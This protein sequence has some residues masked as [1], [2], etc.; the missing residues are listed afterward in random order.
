MMGSAMQEEASSL[1]KVLADPDRSKAVL[2]E[3]TRRTTEAQ[4]AEAVNRA[5]LEAIGNAQAQLIQDMA[6]LDRARTEFN[7]YCDSEAIK[8]TARDEAQAAAKAELDAMRTELAR[9]LDAFKALAA[10]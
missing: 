5:S 7:A 2:E 9:K 3:L 1:L 6:A 10:S 4:A 8:M